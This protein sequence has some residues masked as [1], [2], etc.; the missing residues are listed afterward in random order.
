MGIHNSKGVWQEDQGRIEGII[1]DYFNAIF[2]SDHSTNFEASLSAFNYRV[3][4]KMNKELLIDFK[5]DKVWRALKQMH[6]TKAPGPDDMSIIFYE[7]YWDIVGSNLIKCVLNALNSGVMPSDLN[8][9]FIYIIPKVKSPQ[10]IIEFKPISLCNVIYKI[11]SKVLA[12]RL[13]RILVV[14]IDELQSAFVPGRLITNNV[15]VVLET[16]YCIDQRKK[17][18]EALM[19]IKINMSKAYDRVEW[20][21]LEAMIRSMGFH[22]KWISLI[23]MCVTTVSYSVL[24]NSDPK[25]KITPSRGLR[26]GDPIFPYLF[27]ICAEGL[28]AMLKKEEAIGHIKGISICR[29]VPRISHLLFTDD[30]IVFCR[31]TVEESNRVMKVLEDYER[32][33]G[34]KLNKEK[35]SLFFSKNTNRDVQN[36]VKQQFGA[37]IIRH[38]EKSREKKKAFNRIK[39]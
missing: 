5:V 29:G 12:N 16:M 1:L 10:K 14:V 24:I 35:T 32:D 30:S 23:M 37:Q 17:G 39:D 8:E 13:K 7:N 18:K 22:D 28:S 20:V 15:L 3:T 31:A 27:L 34:Q 4:T 36:H 11:I 38:H 9:T 21:Y 33:S 26:Q 25:G 19:A 2:K 6:P